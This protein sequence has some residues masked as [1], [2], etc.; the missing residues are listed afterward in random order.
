MAAS[1]GVSLMEEL[2]QAMRLNQYRELLQAIHPGDG[3]AED[4]FPSR[5]H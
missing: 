3:I 2:F 1:Q 5:V 4:M